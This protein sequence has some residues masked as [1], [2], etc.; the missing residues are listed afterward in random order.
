VVQSLESCCRQVAK[1]LS[2]HCSW[3]VASAWPVHEPVQSALHFVVQS[4]L[5]E[6]V[7]H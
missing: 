4:A 3:H 2:W 5:V 6:T 7:V 1:L